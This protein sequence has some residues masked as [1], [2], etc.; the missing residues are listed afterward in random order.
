MLVRVDSNDDKDVMYKY[1]CLIHCLNKVIMT[2]LKVY[3]RS[4]I[5]VLARTCYYVL[6]NT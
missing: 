5:N 2:I 6:M 4:C 3:N 1:C